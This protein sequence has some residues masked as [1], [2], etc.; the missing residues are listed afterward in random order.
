MLSNQ[1]SAA[2]QG[3]QE[4]IGGLDVRVHRNHFGRQI[5]S[6]ESDLDLSF[7]A[8]GTDGATPFHG[9]FIRAPVVEEVFS[10]S[11]LEVLARLPN[12]VNRTEGA[13][14]ARPV[15]GAGDIVAVRQGN[16]L[17]TSF[18][19]ELTNDP[20]IHIWWLRGILDICS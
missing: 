4:V 2:K 1:V 20:R 15:D 17:G 14:L 11:Y 16:I 7:L 6:F 8:Q 5:E 19:P 12:R 13:S 9:V 10:N 3:N 18:H